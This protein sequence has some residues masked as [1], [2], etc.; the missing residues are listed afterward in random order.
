MT[1]T[2]AVALWSLVLT[3]GSADAAVTVGV[4][5]LPTRG[6][7]IRVGYVKPDAPI[8]RFVFRAPGNRVP[9]GIE[10]ALVLVAGSVFLHASAWPLRGTS[11]C[12]LWVA[13][14][15][16][17]RNTVHPYRQGF[18]AYGVPATSLSDDPKLYKHE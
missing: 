6:V 15:T 4:V 3:F 1:I 12:R 17:R 16:G 13:G 10:L 14:S 5:V 8:E 18:E 7:T 2:R 11:L 9:V